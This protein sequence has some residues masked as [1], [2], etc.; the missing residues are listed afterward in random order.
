MNR[1]HSGH[2]PGGLAASTGLRAGGGGG[3]AQDARRESSPAGRG[4]VVAEVQQTR[5]EKS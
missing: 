2:T 1:S 3:R 4:P 5:G